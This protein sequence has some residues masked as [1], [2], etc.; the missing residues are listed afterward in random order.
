V[1]KKAFVVQDA[2]HILQVSLLED[3]TRF[4]TC[5]FKIVN[6]QNLHKTYPFSPYGGAKGNQ[7]EPEDTHPLGDVARDHAP[8]TH[9]Q[10]TDS[11]KR[12]E[13]VQQLAPSHDKHTRHR[14]A[15]CK[16]SHA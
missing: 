4:S 3:I 7:K 13:H 14:L 16:Y 5:R 9:E 1:D 10:L 6:S 2:V 11:V 15:F 8:H 12:Q